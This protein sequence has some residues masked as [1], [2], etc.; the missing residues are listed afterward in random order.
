MRVQASIMLREYQSLLQT[1][2]G[3]LMLWPLANHDKLKN[4]L[5]H[6]KD[7]LINKLRQRALAS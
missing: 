1:S 5:R 2:A 4:Q 6:Q 7:W 3:K